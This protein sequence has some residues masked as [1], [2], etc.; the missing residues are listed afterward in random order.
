MGRGSR[1]R[2][3]IFFIGELGA[4]TQKMSWLPADYQE[5]AATWV[6]AMLGFLQKYKFHWS[7]F[8]FH[9]KSSPHLLTGWDYAPTPEWGVPA[10][11][12]L[13][14]EKFEMDRLR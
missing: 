4:N 2:A 11:R 9:P 1:G 12:A 3:V 6:P 7:A 14:G 13:A 10:K 5:D 8:S